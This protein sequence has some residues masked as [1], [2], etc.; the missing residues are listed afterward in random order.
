MKRRKFLKTGLA[1][2]AAG[3][4][5]AG[6]RQAQ[7]QEKHS[8]R[9]PAP[10]VARTEEAAIHAFG[11]IFINGLC[12]DFETGVVL[13]E[14]HRPKPA[15]IPPKKSWEIQENLIGITP[16]QAPRSYEMDFQPFLWINL[17][18]GRRDTSWCSR[19]QARPDV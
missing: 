2:G 17:I 19:R 8:R 14:G 16:E 10:V 6:S 13:Q 7:A 3:P 5:I 15:K 1:I 18:D 4:Y 11:K 9:K 12:P